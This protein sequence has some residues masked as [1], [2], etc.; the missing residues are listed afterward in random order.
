[1]AKKDA[2]GGLLDDVLSRVKDSKPG[3]KSWFERLPHEAQQELNAVRAEFN[4][5]VHQKKAF[6]S[7]I[8][9]AATARGW[10]TGG[11]QAVIAWLGQKR[12]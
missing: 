4:P 2:A 11:P 7:A 1:M 5:A 9:D 8:I 3:F 6:A 12:S 10:E